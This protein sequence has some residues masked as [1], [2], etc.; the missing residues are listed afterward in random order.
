[1][2]ISCFG[3]PSHKQEV[4]GRTGSGLTKQNCSRLALFMK[5]VLP[6]YGSHIPPQTVYDDETKKCGY[7]EE[8]IL[9]LWN[10]SAI[11]CR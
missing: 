7:F 5:V 11:L 1:M 9:S 4:E 6:N 3:D 8:C 2:G 10:M